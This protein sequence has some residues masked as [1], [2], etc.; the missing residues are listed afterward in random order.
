ME[1]LPVEPIDLEQLYELFVGLPLACEF[2]V[3]VVVEQAAGE[4][5]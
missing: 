4:V 1:E 2:D 5:H 3:L